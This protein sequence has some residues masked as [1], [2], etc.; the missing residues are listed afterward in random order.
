MLEFNAVTIYWL[1][2]IGLLVGFIID[3]VMIKRGIGMIGN[4]VWGAV[5][6]IIIGA[7]VIW[8]DMYAPLLYAA[9]GSIAFLFLVNVFSIH[10][11][12]RVTVKAE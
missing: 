11:D 6:S 9:V 1:L 7:V 5:G 2:S 4:V 10:T 12:D 3:L 8:L